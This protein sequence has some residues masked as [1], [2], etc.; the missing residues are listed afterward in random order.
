MALRTTISS[1][2]ADSLIN[3][4]RLG[5]TTL[6]SSSLVSSKNVFTLNPDSVSWV[7]DSV[8]VFFATTL[9]LPVTRYFD[10]RCLDLSAHSVVTLW[11]G[12][13]FARRNPIPKPPLAPL[14]GISSGDTLQLL[15]QQVYLNFFDFSGRRAAKIL[16]SGRSETLSFY[17]VFI[18]ERALEDLNPRHQVLETCVLPTELRAH[19]W[20]G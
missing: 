12:R 6:P 20:L 17:I 15:P 4:C 14:S 5:Q 7:S 1:T 10:A 19:G 9:G 8:F 3:C 18:L 11:G 2:A 13:V 16:A